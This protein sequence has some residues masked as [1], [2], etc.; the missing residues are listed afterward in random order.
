MAIPFNVEYGLSVGNAVAIANVIDTNA[1]ING[2]YIT[3]TSGV[4]TLSSGQTGSNGAQTTTISSNPSAINSASYILPLDIGNGGVLYVD[5]SGFMYLNTPI[6]TGSFNA[7]DGNYTTVYDTIPQL[8]GAVFN[9]ANLYNYAASPSF[10]GSLPINTTY[11]FVIVAYDSYGNPVSTSEFTSVTTSTFRGISI[12]WNGNPAL[13]N[14][15]LWFGTT[16]GGQNKYFPI[17]LSGPFYG[18]YDFT[19]TTGATSGTIPS[20]VNKSASIQFSTVIPTY[21]NTLQPA[22]TT[23]G[24]GVV[25]SNATYTDN[26][27]TANGIVST[28]YMNYFG[29]PTYASNSA[30]V[31]VTNLY[32]TYFANPVAG[33]NTTATNT[34]AIGAA[35]LNVTGNATV[36]NLIGVLANGNSSI[37][38]PAAN[39]NI[40]INAGGGTT[41]LVITTTGVNVNGTLNSSGNANVGN[42]G[43]SQVIATANISAPQ[44]ISSVATGTAPLVVTST[45]QVPNLNVATSGTAGTVT[46]NA[47][48]NITSVG[49]LSSLTVTGNIIS[50]ATGGLFL[51]SGSVSNTTSKI[52]STGD[53]SIFGG[54]S[55]QA[56]VFDGYYNT[57]VSNWQYG[58]TGQYMSAIRYDGLAG[59]LQILTTSSNGTA[60]S[61]ANTRVSMVIDLN[62]NIGIGNGAPTNNLSILGTLYTSGNA[63]VGNIGASSGVFSATLN[64]TGNSA[65]SNV[66][67]TNTYSSSFSSQYIS[68]FASSNSLITASFQK[69]FGDTQLG[70]SILGVKASGFQIIGSSNNNENYP[71]NMLMLTPGMGTNTQ[72][73]S[74]IYFTSTRSTTASLANSVYTA[75]NAGDQLGSLY[76][77]GDNSVSLRSSG[78]LIQGVA[79]E[80]WTANTNGGALIFSTTPVSTPTTANPSERMRITANGNI[81]IGN[82]APAYKFYVNGSIGFNGTIYDDTNNSY[83]LKPSGTSVFN[84]ANINGTLNATG[85]TTIGGTFNVSSSNL[86]APAWTTSGIAI[87][88]SSTTFT[89]TTS[90]GT[91]GNVYMNLFDTQ[92]VAATNAVTVTNLY[93]TYFKNPARGANVS[94]TAAYALGADSLSISVN[95]GIAGLVT[96]GGLSI[97]GNS[98]VTSST[99]SSTVQIA[100]GATVSGNTKT[101]NIGTGGASGSTTT[102]TI[103]SNTAPGTVTV[104]GSIQPLTANI[105]TASTITP[106]AGTTNQYNVTALAS[107]ATIAAPSGTPVD[108]QKLLIRIKD[109]GTPQ[110][111]TW[112]TTSGAYRARGV[113][114]PVNTVAST[115]VYI[116]CVYN[117]QDTYWDVIAISS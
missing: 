31:T 74:E 113:T 41:E 35:S 114:L 76:F 59:K 36:G 99:G 32:S 7:S 22:W 11:Y 112:T 116:G 49:T 73:G 9:Q 45:T 39:G 23:N 18:N 48:P 107:A 106:T 70:A 56:L 46:T 111:L 92:T 5:S 75:L 20:K 105:T 60:A 34:Y 4:I 66:S 16:S 89:D 62:G 12:E 40:N 85:N 72:R 38:I 3:S 81:G 2:N 65:F 37:S 21:A 27:T 102:I 28:A 52:Q 44:L 61:N 71:S 8:Y 104:N 79:A 67:A 33:A 64:V 95:A 43:A 96:A 115:P 54:G 93:G 19:K 42:I 77:A 15:Q 100:Y 108:G 98:N 58:V 1:N 17:T 50:G 82:S 117:A 68:V 94:G 26:T 13:T 97:T 14:Y 84:Y 24:I 109:N 30:N 57:A 6:T 88:Q 103:G 86:S 29:T 91:V 55:A 47:Q 110:G 69:N 53:I 80:T 87:K 90:T 63:N 78:A 10:S 25:I 101:V 83:Y 51:T